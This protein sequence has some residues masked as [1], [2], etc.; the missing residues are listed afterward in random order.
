MK[1]LFVKYCIFFFA[2]I[3]SQNFVA[4][5]LTATDTSEKSVRRYQ[6]VIN[7][8]KQLVRF[9]EYSFTQRGIPKHMRNLAIIESNLD[10]SQISAAGASGIWQFMIGHAN[11]YGL[12]ESNRA[13]MYKSTK[14]VTNSLIN[15][16]NK[17]KN[18]VTVVAA[19]N[20]GEGNVNKAMQRA[21]SKNYTDFNSF[22][23]VETQNH[24]QKYLNA[25]YATGELN[26]VLQDYYKTSFKVK[27]TTS[28]PTVDV[29]KFKENTLKNRAKIDLLETTINGAYRLDVILKYLKVERI[30]F[31]KW[32]PEMEKNL[33]QKGET[34]L[35]L[36]RN[37]MDIFTINKYKI[38]TESLKK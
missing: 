22:L 21:G 23:P 34:I 29:K 15:L 38:L 25:C 9:I 16:Y 12:T 33:I 24:V 8:N 19:Y 26:A 14:A 37:L 11:D 28:K 20:C 3:F 2:I 18:W 4:Q 31:L 5:R 1:Q 10:K 35:V 30:Q 17:Y 13:D 36:P 7:N 27:E 32:N 6:N